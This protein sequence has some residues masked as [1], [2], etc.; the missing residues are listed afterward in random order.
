MENTCPVCGYQHL[1]EPAWDQG[2]ASDEICPSCGTQFG[3]DDA[4]G[5]F[6]DRREWVHRQLRE[7]W[8]VDGCTWSS[9]RPIPRDW[10]PLRQVSDL[11]ADGT[12]RSAAP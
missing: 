1:D 11:T 3:L 4:A 12:G 9:T 7:R 10:D 5:G 6:L 8:Q 2:S